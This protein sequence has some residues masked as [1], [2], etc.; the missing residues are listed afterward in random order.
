MTAFK[1]KLVA[2]L[3]TNVQFKVF[4]NYLSY[5]E[6]LILKSIEVNVKITS[7]F[8]YEP[9]Q[10]AY[11]TILIQKYCLVGSGSAND[12]QNLIDVEVFDINEVSSDLQLCN[13]VTTRN[14]RNNFL[15]KVVDGSHYLQCSISGA[16]IGY[17]SYAGWP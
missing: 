8:L 2:I 9:E 16:I 10:V 6:M 7:K 3:G 4:L 13:N 11:R 1:N 12:W 5:V 17:L 15:P 14:F